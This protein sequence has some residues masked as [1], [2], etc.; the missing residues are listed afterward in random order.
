MR[1]P[2]LPKYSLRILLGLAATALLLANAMRFV[3]IGLIERLELISYDTRL[4]LT[5]PGGVDPRIVIVDLD[6]KSLAEIGRWPWGR[7]R[8]A[9]LVYKLFERHQ[10]AVLGFDVLFSEPDVSS[11]LDKLRLLERGKLGEIPAFKAELS[12][13]APAL[14]HDGLFAAAMAKYPV[15]LK[16]GRAHV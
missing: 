15:V 9:E 1:L 6:E 3:D 11:G 2:K 14:D 5:M 8:M 12:K 13:L 4:K 7:D 16:I 10:I